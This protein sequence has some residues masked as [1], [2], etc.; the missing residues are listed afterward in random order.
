MRDCNR[1]STRREI[2]KDKDRWMRHLIIDPINPLVR[3]PPQTLP[4][5]EREMKEREIIEKLEGR[6]KETKSLIF[7]PNFHTRRVIMSK[8]EGG[9]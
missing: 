6:K 5:R 9:E 4:K 2:T 8:P 1:M 7:L 3:F